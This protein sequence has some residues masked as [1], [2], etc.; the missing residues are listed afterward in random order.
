MLTFCLLTLQSILPS[1]LNGFA[2]GLN[3]KIGRLV[4]DVISAITWKNP[5]PDGLS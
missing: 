4:D 2:P 3:F 5:L 1:A